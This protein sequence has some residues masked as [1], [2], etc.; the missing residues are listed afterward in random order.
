[1]QRKRLNINPNGKKMSERV[2]Y[3][4]DMENPYITHDDKYIESVWWSLKQIFD[5]G[6]IYKGHKIVPTACAAAR[7]CPATR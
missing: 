1:M 5:R 2:G 7:R 6:L 4:A 3:W